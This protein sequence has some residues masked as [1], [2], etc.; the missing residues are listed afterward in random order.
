MSNGQLGKQL[1]ERLKI[2]DLQRHGMPKDWENAVHQ[3]SYHEY[4]VDESFKTTLY[5]AEKIKPMDPFEV[6]VQIGFS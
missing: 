1:F 4:N 3:V 2:T 6:E 5:D